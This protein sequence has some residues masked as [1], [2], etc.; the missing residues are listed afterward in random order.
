MQFCKFLCDISKGRFEISHWLVILNLWLLTHCSPGNITRAI[1]WANVDQNMCRCVVS[2]RDKR[3]W[4]NTD[5]PV[6]DASDI[7]SCLFALNVNTPCIKYGN[8]CCPLWLVTKATRPSGGWLQIHLRPGW[9]QIHRHS[10]RVY[11]A[12]GTRRV[13]WAKSVFSPK[14]K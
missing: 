14:L 3:Q 2:L 9:S 13:L 4:L 1:T 7:W 8:T 10:E 6:Q 5:G 12:L 11:G